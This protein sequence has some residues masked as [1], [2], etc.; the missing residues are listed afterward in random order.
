ML[1]AMHFDGW[2]IVQRKWIWTNSFKIRGKSL[3]KNTCD[4][5]IKLKTFRKDYV[6]I[7]CGVVVRWSRVEQMV[8]ILWRTLSFFPSVFF[9]RF[10]SIHSFFYS[11]KFHKTK[12][13]ATWSH[14]RMVPGSNPAKYFLFL[15]VFVFCCYCCFFFV[16]FLRF[17]VFA[18]CFVCLFVFFN[19]NLNNYYLMKCNT[20][21]LCSNQGPVSRKS[22]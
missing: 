7:H 14:R 5:C 13:A 8:R 11:N 15:S 16:F 10:W 9:F 12:T 21:K 1:L 2:S 6:I 17:C 3:Y 20:S 22:R 19:L 18:L 4:A